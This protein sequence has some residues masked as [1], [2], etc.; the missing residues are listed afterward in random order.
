MI[1]YPLFL[2]VCFFLQSSTANG[3]RADIAVLTDWLCGSFSSSRQSNEDSAFFDIRLSIQRIW[4]E[5]GD[6]PWLYVEQAMAGSLS[7]PYRQRIY[8]L[9]TLSDSTFESAVYTLRDPL[10]FTGDRKALE[11]LLPDS[12]EEKIGCAVVLSWDS[13][14]K[15]FVGATGIKTCASELRGASYAT[16][17]VILTAE[18]MKTWDRGYT[19]E[20][21]QVWG[22]V[23]GGYQFNRVDK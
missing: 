19:R 13:Q 22:A 12:L 1:R 4:E 8:R 6:G 20:G 10:R 15:A 5:R 7:R 9:R 18:G 2:F 11:K 3:Q 16:S 21:V 14:Q 23:K 17:E